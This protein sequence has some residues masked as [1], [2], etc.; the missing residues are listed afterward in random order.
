MA[1]GALVAVWMRDGHER[2][3]LLA[4]G[5]RSALTKGRRI[6][7]SY[8]CS[9]GRRPEKDACNADTKVSEAACSLPGCEE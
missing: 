2:M 4:N 6:A 3:I 8:G 9:G 7:D 1:G 5:A